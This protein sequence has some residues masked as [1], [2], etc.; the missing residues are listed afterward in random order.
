MLTTRTIKTWCFVHKW[1]S[2]ICT[3]F[4]LL[5]CLTGLPL[6]FHDEI[7]QLFGHDV[8]LPALPA[9]TPVASLDRI[10][11]VSKEQY[12][13]EYPLVLVWD[14]HHPHLIKL[15]MLPSPDAAPEQTHVLALDARTAR[16]LDEPKP[17]RGF[18]YVMLNLHE[19]LFAGLPGELFLG[20]MG[21]L[22]A[23]SIVSGAVVY[24]PFMRK[25]DFG[26]V[27]H[28]GTRRLKWLDLHNLLGIVTL[29]WALVVGATGVMNTLAE[30]LFD[31][32][33]AQELPSLLAPY[34]GQPS[35]TRLGS[36]QAAVETARA[37]LPGMEVTSVV[38]PN[39]RFGS[40]RHY[41]IWTQGKTPLTSR[42]STPVMVDA[43]TGQLTAVRDLPWYLRALQVSR[44]LH[45]GD[46]GGLPMKTL[47]A[48]LDGVTIVVLSSGLYLW[49]VRR[50]TPIE[51]RLEGIEPRE[52]APT[53]AA[54]AEATG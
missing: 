35:P 36:V 27:R 53:G 31:L 32:W 37:A 24:G 50:K 2:L 44:P 28:D 1:S 33:R 23:A 11:D 46:Y 30:P 45:F 15:S 51:A 5:L 18:M 40:P 13:G 41:L 54:S 20:L 17:E 26:T 43:E 42:L 47:W 8:P 4:L 10:V 16:V 19:E 34:Q 38:F 21:L 52:A 14:D 7:D 3:A 6:I 39:T 25:L 22:F 48:L 12:P 29:T 49:L 9:G